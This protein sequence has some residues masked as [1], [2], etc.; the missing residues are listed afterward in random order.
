MFDKINLLS[1]FTAGFCFM[2]A[3]NNPENIFLMT[4][5]MALGILNG[6]NALH[7]HLPETETK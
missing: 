1:A 5:F 7:L 3:I 6:I 2:A 4:G